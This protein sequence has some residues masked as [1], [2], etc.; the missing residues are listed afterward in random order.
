MLNHSAGDATG[1]TTPNRS[2]AARRGEELQLLLMLVEEVTRRFFQNII[3]SII[4][5]AT[6]T[7][8]QGSDFYD[9][10]QL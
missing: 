10:I 1:G 7:A 9:L 5:L 2:E 4:R 8:V 3:S 6:N